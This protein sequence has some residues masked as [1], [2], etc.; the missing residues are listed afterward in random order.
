MRVQFGVAISVRS[1][2]VCAIRI[3]MPKML[4]ICVRN[5][6]V[7]ETALDKELRYPMPKTIF[8]CASSAKTPREYPKIK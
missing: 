1:E 3:A 8:E 6:H 2:Q 7:Y 4:A 5:T